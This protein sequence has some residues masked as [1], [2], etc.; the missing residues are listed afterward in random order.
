MRSTPETPSTS[1]WWVFE[2]SAQRAVVEALDEPQLPQRLRAVQ[3]LGEDPRG[4]R[5]RACPRSPGAAAPVW[6]TW[7]SRLNV[8]SSIQ[9]Q[10]PRPERRRGELLAVARDEVQP[11]ADVRRRSSRYGG[12]RALEQRDAADVHVRARRPPGAGSSRRRALRR[13]EMFLGHL[14]RERIAFVTWPTT[15]PRRPHHR[16]LDRH[17][18]RHR[19]S[20]SPRRGWT[21][22]AT[23]RRVETLADL[24]AAGCRTLALDVT[25]EASMQRGRRGASSAR[26]G[27][28]GVL[29]NNAGYSQSGTV[30]EVADRRRS[31]ASSRRTSS[32][33]CGCASSCC[34][35]CASRA[36]A[37]S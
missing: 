36:G 23:A 7:Y 6:R 32:A 16:L 33:R 25:D 1:A 4:E 11:R 35:G 20:T 21:V 2:T 26:H 8:G 31:A 18:P 28:V 37:R 10:R 3:A 19:A 24:E 29:V 14:P 13:V 5:V 22:Y 12:A 27:A 17:R 34:P 9:R 30:E 15:L